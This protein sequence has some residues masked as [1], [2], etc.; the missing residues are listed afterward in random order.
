MEINKDP[1]APVEK[2]DDKTS[3]PQDDTSKDVKPNDDGVDYKAEYE[4]LQKQKEQ[5]EYTIF[6]LK[7]EK[8]GEKQEDKNEGEDEKPDI[9]E[10]IDEK[11][12]EIESKLMADKREAAITASAKS[13]DEANVIKWYLDNRIKPSGNLSEDIALA[14]TLA[15]RNLIEK[16]FKAMEETIKEKGSFSGYGGSGSQPAKEKPDVALSEADRRFM[17]S[18]GVSEDEIS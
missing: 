16:N 10:L 8:K 3:A 12:S 17:K 4:K 14:K 18:F 11:M 2:V 5:A 15:N 7:K 13:Q 9:I 6:Q 1:Q